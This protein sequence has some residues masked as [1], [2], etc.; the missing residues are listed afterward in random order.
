MTTEITERR[1]AEADRERLNEQLAQA[2]K[3][4]SIGRL[5]GGVAHDFNNMLGVILGHVELALPHAAPP[6]PLRASLT[7]IEKAARRSADLTRQLLAFARK[8]TV[9]PKVLDLNQ[10]VS[11]MLTILRRLIGENI[12][13][14]WRPG[15]E[16]WPIKVDPSQIDQILANLCAN[17]RDAITGVGKIEIGTENSR[18]STACSSENEGCREGDFI[19]L[20]ISDTGC[21]MDPDTRAKLFEPFYTT[22]EVGK[23]TGLGLAM[24]YG[25]VQQNKGFV[26]VDSTPGEGSSFRL[27]FPRHMLDGPTRPENV[28]ERPVAGTETVLL[29]EDEAALLN[30]TGEMLAS[31]GYRVIPAASP[32]T[33]IQTAL[34]FDGVIDLLL[35]DIV[36]PEMNGWQLVETLRPIRPAMKLLFTSGYT[37]TALPHP[38][39]LEGN[40]HFIQKPFSMRDLSRKIREALGQ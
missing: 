36:M 5:A 31:L 9:I 4:E 19:V 23:G 33:A 6:G 15:N 35:T 39:I 10:V 34:K 32:A 12:K 7:E 21:G 18:V 13:L 2:Y 29:V 11:N 30:M 38:D 40:A 17:A 1:Q 8:Q 26:T 14:V 3:M 37:A 28:E 24:V 20:T 25:I 22:K 16:L 27:F